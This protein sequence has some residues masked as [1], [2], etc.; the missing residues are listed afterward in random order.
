MSLPASGSELNGSSDQLLEGPHMPG[1]IGRDILPMTV[2]NMTFLVNRMG[3]DCSPLQFIRELTQNA[4]DA[5]QASGSGQV[6]WDVDWTYFQHTGVRKLACIDTGNAAS[7]PLHPTMNHIGV[8]CSS[9]SPKP[10]GGASHVL[11]AVLGA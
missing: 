9:P 3:E 11:M 5:L 7:F 10:S 8:R 2:K 6:I 1:D 4:L